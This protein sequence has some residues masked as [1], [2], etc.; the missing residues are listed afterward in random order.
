MALENSGSFATTHTVIKA[1]SEFA[2]W[3]EKDKKHL[4]DIANSNSQ[5]SCILDDKDVKAFYQKIVK[6]MEL[7][8]GTHLEIKR[9]VEK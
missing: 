4:L 2:D 5:V 7:S 6:D 8:N 9:K 3:D 1:L